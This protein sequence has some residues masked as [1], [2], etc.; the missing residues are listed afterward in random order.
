M[1][2]PIA[3]MLGRAF[4]VSESERY[5]TNSLNTGFLFI[6][7]VTVLVTVAW[8]VSV[9]RT[10]DLPQSFT[11]SRYPI[12]S[13]VALG[14]VFVNA[15]AY[16][17]AN[18]ASVRLPADHYYHT[19]VWP[20]FNSER[21]TLWDLF[22]LMFG[23]SL[24]SLFAIFAVLAK[25]CGV[26]DTILS[27]LS[28]LG[29]VITLGLIILLLEPYDASEMA[30]IIIFMSTSTWSI[31]FA[32]NVTLW[33]K[34]LFRGHTV[35]SGISLFAMSFALVY[36]AVYWTLLPRNSPITFLSQVGA[37]VTSLALG[38]GIMAIVRRKRY[39]IN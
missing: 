28:C 23:L 8:L 36:L 34:R 18:I 6:A 1:G 25:K 15:P 35:A 20:L 32:V 14:V 38:E 12:L 2:W 11:A 9:S 10:M 3:I 33:R 37:F 7:L 30:P 29:L 21:G 5:S 4:N 22:G 39:R 13:V 16:I 27:L 31:L 26:T 17:F 24:A 19:D